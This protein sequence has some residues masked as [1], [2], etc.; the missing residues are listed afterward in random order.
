MKI[1]NIEIRDLSVYFMRKENMKA[2]NLND[3]LNVN[4]EVILN[5]LNIS[6]KSKDEKKEISSGDVIN[7]INNIYI[8]C[9]L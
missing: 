7:I 6:R 3:V 5:N 8:D 4:P 2:T 1:S 9:I